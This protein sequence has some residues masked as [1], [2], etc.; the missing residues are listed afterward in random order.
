M[1]SD[2][3]VFCCGKECLTA[4]LRLLIGMRVFSI[5]R[6]VRR[7]KR[8]EGDGCEEKK[9]GKETRRS[10]ERNQ[11]LMAAWRVVRIRQPAMSVYAGGIGD[12]GEDKDVV[13]MP[14]TWLMCLQS[15]GARRNTQTLECFCHTASCFIRVA[16]EA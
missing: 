1:I 16:D 6:N 5:V 3:A 2:Y 8:G 13:Q 7:G 14:T 10:A 4:H 11:R 9:S 15:R 12:V